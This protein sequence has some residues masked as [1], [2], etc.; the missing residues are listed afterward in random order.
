MEQLAG[1]VAVNDAGVFPPVRRAISIDE[2]NAR[3]VM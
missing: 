2:R 3:R 1:E